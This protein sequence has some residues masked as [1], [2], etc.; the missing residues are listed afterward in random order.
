PMLID[1]GFAKE[2]IS[3]GLKEGEKPLG[4]FRDFQSGKIGTGSY[5]APETYGMGRSS[6]KSDIYTAGLIYMAMLGDVGRLVGRHDEQE[7]IEERQKYNLK[8]KIQRVYM[9]KMEPLYRNNDSLMSLKVPKDKNQALLRDSLA[10]FINRMTYKKPEVRPSAL[11]VSRFF[12]RM[13]RYCEISELVG[14]GFESIDDIMVV[15]GLI[16]KYGDQYVTF[17]GKYKHF[18]VENK[19]GI[20]H[21][22]IIIGHAEIIE[23]LG[24]DYRTYGGKLNQGK[25]LKNLSKMTLSELDRWLKDKKNENLLHRF[26]SGDAFIKIVA[27]S[28]CDKIRKNLHTQINQVNVDVF[29]YA[30]SK[31][32]DRGLFALRNA[33]ERGEES[34][35][36]LIMSVDKGFFKH[37]LGTEEVLTMDLIKERIKEI[38]QIKGFDE[39]FMKLIR[40]EGFMKSFAL[41]K[42]KG[43]SEKAQCMIYQ[44]HLVDKLQPLEVL[45]LR[46]E[47]LGY[48]YDR[49]LKLKEDYDE[50]QKKLLERA[51]SMKR[52]T[53][54]QTLVRGNL[55][56]DKVKDLTPK[57]LQEKKRSLVESKFSK[58]LSK[59]TGRK[60]KKESKLET[61]SGRKPN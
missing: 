16:K 40:R 19:L 23:G 54:Y 39:A 27:N 20:L 53:S 30:F 59:I 21:S 35:I 51:L 26:V 49:P 8:L 46:L 9:L 50:N 33:V 12:R 45:N 29:L 38:G 37:I 11:Q 4:K 42:V 57:K 61:P 15:K 13:Q 48:S 24:A 55:A 17:L 22:M 7:N 60:N 36:N 18:S 34:V 1:F 10:R 14:K 43:L 56:M 44:R 32:K 41:A 2:L 31:T 47:S 52:S 6:N 58:L 3:S 5:M 25:N 28:E